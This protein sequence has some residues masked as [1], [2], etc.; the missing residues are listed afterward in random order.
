M[1]QVPDLVQLTIDARE[2]TFGPMSTQQIEAMRGIRELV[3]L[4]AS[5][6]PRAEHVDSVSVG[7][8]SNV[9]VRTLEIDGTTYFYE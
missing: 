1:T 3:E 5:L 4:G 6:Q 9:I 7:Q 2:A 8:V